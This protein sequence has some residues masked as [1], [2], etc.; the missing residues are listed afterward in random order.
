MVAEDNFKYETILAVDVGST[1][2]KTVLIE[3]VDGEYRLRG[4]AEAPTTVEAPHEDVTI[5]LRDSINR[6]QDRMSRRFLRDGDLIMSRDEDGAGV[7]LMVGTSSAGGGLQMMCVGLVDKLTSESAQRAALGAG[8]IVMDVISANDERTVVERVQLLR[9]QRP[10]MILLAGGTDEGNVSH[11]VALAEYIAAAEPRSRLGE[12]HRVPVIFAGNKKARDM[13]KE[14]LDDSLDVYVTDNIR[15]TLEEENLDS[16]R[17]EIHRLFLDHVMEHAPGYSTLLQWADRNVQPT[18]TAVGDMMRLMSS[19]YGVNVMGVDIGG[20]T[21]DVFS[22]VDGAFNR[23]VSANIG[24]SYSL[25]NVFVQSGASDILRWIP[26][27]ASEKNLRDWLYNKSIRPTGLPI[28]TGELL[29]EQAVGREALRLAFEQ[30]QRVIV[31]LK[32]LKQQASFDR[33]FAQDTSGAPL[34]L[35]GEMD[36][37][38]GSGGLLS[39]AP[40]R[41]QSALM[42]LDAFLPEGIARLYVDSVFMMPHL[43][44]LSRLAPEIAHEVFVRDCLVPLG[45]VIAPSGEGGL[46]SAMAEVRAETEDGEEFTRVIRKGQLEVIP[47]TAEQAVHLQVAPRR[48]FDVGEGPGV[49][50]RA[51]VRGGEVGLILDGR[52]RPIRFPRRPGQQREKVREW[53]VA[54]GAHSEEQIDK[55]IGSQEVAR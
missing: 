32:G 29:M 54:M 22:V 16:V 15:P 53:L 9:N 45:T 52:G 40:H 3:E 18:P 41:A 13:V 23:S 31:G 17:D 47:V 7:D 30:H 5:G 48:G 4:R 37:I 55:V 38:I 43:G 11:A 27:E 42:L 2:T 21:T 24:M 25:A 20:A 19:E 6:L 14:I 28:T 46:G 51:D 49:R 34:V 33:A 1:T 26:A 36:V 50:I 44:A 8:A 39:H 35:P 10:D 12:E